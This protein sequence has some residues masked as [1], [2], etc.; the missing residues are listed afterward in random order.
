[1]FPILL[2]NDYCYISTI[3]TFGG[4]GANLSNKIHDI[5]QITEASVN[6]LV[7]QYNL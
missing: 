2:Y 6:N 5:I 4:Y 7:T 1:M 3:H